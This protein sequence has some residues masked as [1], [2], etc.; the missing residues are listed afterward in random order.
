MYSLENGASWTGDLKNAF[1]TGTTYASLI[2][3]QQEYN[4]SN[5]LKEAELKDVRY[6]PNA[7]F[8]GQAVSRMLTIKMVN[9]EDSNLNFEN[10]DVQFK[11]GT[12]YNGIRYNINYGNF[13]VD[14]APKNDATNGTVT[15]IAYDYMIKFNKDYIN[16]VIYPCTLKDLLLDVCSQAGVELGTSNF[17][18][19]NFIVEDN[20]FEGK[21]LREILQHIAKCAFSW[22]R[23]GQDN[24]L[25]LDFSVNNNNVERITIDDYKTDSFKKANEYYGPVNKVTFGDSDIKGQE[26]SVQDNA[27]IQQNGLTEI[28]INDNYFAYTTEKRH[29]LIQAG[30][31]LFGLRYM[32]IQSLDLIG[33]IYLDCNDIIEVEDL[34]GNVFTS[35]VFSHIINYNGITSDNIATTGE[36]DNEREYSNTNNSIAQNARVEVIVDRAN[37]KITQVVGEVDGQNQK[38][39]EVTQTLDE[40]RSQISDISE[41][42]ESQETS[43]GTLSF[44]NINQSE[45]IRIVIHSTGVNI[46]KLH[47]HT[48]LKPSP[49][50]KIKTR[51][52]RFKNTTTNEI[53]DYELPDDLLYYDNENYDEFILNYEGLSCEINKKCKWN[54]DGTVG[55]LA[56]PRTDSYTFPHIELTNGDYTIQVIQYSNAYLFARLMVQNYYTTQFATRAELNSDIRQTVNN[57]NLSVNSKFSNYSTTTEMNSAIDLKANEITSSVSETYATKETL[58]NNYSTIE[59]TSKMI[60]NT[61]SSMTKDNIETVIVEYALGTSTTTAPTSGWSSTAPTWQQGKYMWQRTKTKTSDGTEQISDPTCI[62]GAKG[63]DGTNGV[64]ISSI[65]EYYAVSSSNTSAP[66]D[67]AFKTTMQTMTT[68]NK[69]LWNYE[70]ITYSNNSK[71]ST[72]KRVIGT[73][74]DKGTDGTNGIGIK[75][76]VNKYQ[77]STSNT[78]APTTWKDTPQTM[79]PTNKYLWNYEIITYSDNTTSTSTPA[80]IG[81]YG[82]K[83]NAGTNG[84]SVSSITEYYAVSSSNTA[85]PADSSFKTT[86]QKMTATNKYLWNYEVIK[87]SNNT[88]QNTNKRVIGV[89]GDKGQAG[90]NGADGIGIKNVTNKYQVSSSNTTAPTSWKDTPQTM[91]A[92]NKYLWNYEIITYSDNTTSTS[93]PA[94]IGTYGEKGDKGDKGNTGDTGKGVKG[95]VAQYYLSSSKTTQ[96][97]GSWA[98]TQPTYKKD[99]YYWTRTKITWTDNTTT[100]TTPI[101]VEEINSLN[102]SVASL[103]IEAGNIKSSVEKK[104]DNDKIISTI[105][106]TAEAIQID[107]SK[108]SL[109]GKTIN[110]TSGNITIDSDKFSVDKNGNMTCTGAT[111]NGGAINSNNFSVDKNGNITATG[112]TIGGFGL[113]SDTFET[114]LKINRDYTA[115]DV[116]RIRQI[117]MGE[118]TPTQA[119]YEKYDLNN[120]GKI[121]V[122]DWHFVNRF[123]N[124]LE[125]KKK[126]YILDTSDATKAIQIFDETTG[127]KTVNIGAFGTYINYL[128]ASNLNIDNGTALY[129]NSI[130]IP[131]ETGRATIGEVT[132][133]DVSYPGVYLINSNT[134][135]IVDIT[136]DYIQ[137]WIGYTKPS[138]VYSGA[139][140]YENNSGS[141]GTITL[142]DY[143]YN[144]DFLEIYFADHNNGNI[145][146]M[147]KVENPDGKNAQMQILSQSGTDIRVNVQRATIS[148]KTITK[149]YGQVNYMSGGN[150]TTNEIYIE[151][152]VGYRS[153]YPDS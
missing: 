89:Y 63:Q 120:D 106:Q 8:I 86:M 75:S 109:N 29:E 88:T 56:S 13:I 94:V 47:P 50:L 147:I 127:K 100:Y 45:P 108:I 130:N 110:L 121:S 58:T 25:Y 98:E 37:K 135:N 125:S 15:F 92:T 134:G 46:A 48:N 118:I 71:Q 43:T 93:T 31:S 148:G 96:T 85:A 30:T 123:V 27:S 3:N 84:V 40:L 57:I 142:S 78:T 6:V 112:G 9:N 104:V 21:Q 145:K 4:E 111:I 19:E 128:T 20:Q 11:I 5:F 119:D 133:G 138:L 34:E 81:A 79:T 74:G 129:E 77:V 28:K 114:E 80:V 62:A 52:L 49:T 38:I 115:N 101:L 69:Y 61:V 132:H 137:F 122:I 60:S 107:A 126:K 7:G 23:I 67:S 16:R 68:T 97:G 139:I 76:V 70:V 91:T 24:R 35:R 131:I 12:I 17:A 33:L 83:G 95:V 140:L 103:T 149:Q 10:A 105:N 99:Y 117:I 153:G 53:F 82:D 141:A 51:T 116:T 124:N 39:S 59:Q 36:S 87:Y 26:E 54:S 113:S 41:I 146:Q 42:T 102:E 73:Y 22:A 144:Y 64:S 32:P 143:A 2:Y 65:T 152:V 72:I 1:K 150:Y 55:L 151:K 18:N 66:A 44:E 136:N 14:E 90:T